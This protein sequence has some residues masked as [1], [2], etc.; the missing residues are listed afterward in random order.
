MRWSA[1]EGGP[2]KTAARL[3]ALTTVL[4]VGIAPGVAPAAGA[5]PQAVI[6]SPA[7]GTVLPQGA[8]VQFGFFCASDTS[9]VVSCDGSQ[10][11]GSSIDTTNAGTHTLSVTATDFDGRTTTATAT[12]TVLDLTPPHVDFRVPAD[13]ATYAQGA[14]LAY[15]YGCADDAGGLGIQACIAGNNVL[16]GTP[17]DTRTLGT[18]TFDVVAV[19]RAN[20]VTHQ[21]IKY[22]IADRTPPAI[23]INAPAD[24]ATY[25]RGQ[26]VFVSFS[27]DDGA[28]GSGVHGCN[29]DLPLG[30][31][32][33]TST[34]GSKSFGVDAYDNAGNESEAKSTYSVVYGFG[35]FV[36]PAAAYPMATSMKAGQSV[37]VKF[38]LTGDQGL[39]IF[40]DG[41]PAWALCGS[42]DTAPA[43]GALSYNASNDRYTY[44]ATTAKSWAGTCRDL[45][46]TLADGTVHRLRLTFTK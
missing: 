12:Y 31:L 46:V 11:L 17:L 23:T 14:S 25:T 26:Q 27:C 3:V 2:V 36:S 10:P 38:S 24:G 18:Y 30:T 41:S 40:A 13:G 34:L 37:P 33:D 6:V 39:A 15:D 9:F 35:G 19:D 32:L 20:N 29:G 42:S 22:T 1:R 28:F 45:V 43:T 8:N 16:P 44:L 4:I 21:T 7:D 5:D